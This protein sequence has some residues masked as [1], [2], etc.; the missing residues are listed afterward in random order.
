VKKAK[1]EAWERAKFQRGKRR[2]GSDEEAMKAIEDD[3]DTDEE[4]DK[5]D[6]IPWDGLA[7]DDDARTSLQP[8]ALAPRSSGPT[9]TPTQ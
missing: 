2:Q 7:C 4:R 9:V 6:D 5:W 1:K 8:S 3:D